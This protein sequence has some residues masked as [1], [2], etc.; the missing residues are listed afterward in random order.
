MCKL[1]VGIHRAQRRGGRHPNRTALSGSLLRRL[2]RSTGTPASHPLPTA[3]AQ[4]GRRVRQPSRPTLICMNCLTAR[5]AMT[6]RLGDLFLTYDFGAM[7]KE[8]HIEVSYGRQFAVT[9]SQSGGGVPPSA[10]GWTP[11]VDRFAEARVYII[12]DNPSNVALLVA[13]LQR[14]GFRKLF[15]EVDSRRVLESLSVV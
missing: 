10:A 4:C 14:A 7:L 2:S 12:D 5:A 13:I 1:I 15:T 6:S 3:H 11:L 8:A 9:E